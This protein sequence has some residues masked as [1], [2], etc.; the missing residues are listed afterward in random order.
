[1]VK[2]EICGKECKGKIGYGVHLKRSHSNDER[3]R[4]YTKWLMDP[5]PTILAIV[6]LLG[7]LKY[8]ERKDK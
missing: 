7:T 1:M 5:L 3:R 6:V 4:L 2:C 8:I